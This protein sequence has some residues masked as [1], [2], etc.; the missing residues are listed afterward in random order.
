MAL[1]IEFNA[2]NINRANHD[3]D[4]KRVGWSNASI[5]KEMHCLKPW[6]KHRKMIKDDMILIVK[7][8]ALFAN[9]KLE[10]WHLKLLWILL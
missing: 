10:I 4:E 5:E 9:K 6:R 1:V 2:N 8:I 3:K 7:K